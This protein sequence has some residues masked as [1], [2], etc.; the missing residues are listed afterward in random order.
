[1][2]TCNSTILFNFS[3]QVLLDVL[4]CSMPCV[5]ASAKEII[6]SFKISCLELIWLYKL[7]AFIPM[8]VA[9]SL[10]VIALSPFSLKSLAAVLIISS[11]RVISFIYLHLLSF[12]GFMEHPTCMLLSDI[13]FEQ[14][15]F[16]IKVE[17][18]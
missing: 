5:N 9:K 18:T 8:A 17:D 2:D 16:I 15:C 3:T 1:M 6:I 13:S 11:L 4:I 14:G 12:N 10:M 7:A